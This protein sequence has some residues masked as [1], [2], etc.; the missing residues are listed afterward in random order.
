MP[1]SMPRFPRVTRSET[2]IVL[3]IIVVIGAIFA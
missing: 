3:L 1:L 2:L